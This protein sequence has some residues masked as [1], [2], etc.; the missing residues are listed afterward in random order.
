M[1]RKYRSL[2]QECRIQAALT[3]HPEAR[4]EL[5]KMEREY[6]L[7]ADWLERQ[8]KEDGAASPIPQRGPR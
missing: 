8:S 2:E 6:K 3:G 7:L 1:H 5:E 4:R